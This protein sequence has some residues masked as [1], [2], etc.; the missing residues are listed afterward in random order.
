MDL[1]ESAMLAFKLRKFTSASTALEP[2]KD[3]VL[4]HLKT[5]AGA[6][7]G[8]AAVGDEGWTPVVASLSD[9]EHRR[10]SWPYQKPLI[11]IPSKKVTTNLHTP[12][13]YNGLT[14]LEETLMPSII[15]AVTATLMFEFMVFATIWFI[16]FKTRRCLQHLDD[17]KL[18]RE[19]L[20]NIAS[21]AISG[22]STAVL[23]TFTVVSLIGAIESVSM[24]KGLL[25]AAILPP[26]ALP[27]VF[28]IRQRRTERASPQHW[29]LHWQDLDASMLHR[30]VWQLDHTNG[31]AVL[32]SRACDELHLY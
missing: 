17:A 1:E 9:A 10:L 18:V 11:K 16:D 21:I 32:P 12:Q 22:L 20:Q 26:L 14:D 28:L 31:Q 13:C 27:I 30:R 7:G 19:D 2:A 5:E 23:A 24:R 3:A 15:A 25:L 8:P 4:E 6:W 29:H